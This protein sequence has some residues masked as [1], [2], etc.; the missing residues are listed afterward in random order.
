M[1]TQP[2]PERIA[3]IRAENL[4]LAFLA[5]FRAAQRKKTTDLKII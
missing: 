5:G 3:D 2:T 1:T 4:R